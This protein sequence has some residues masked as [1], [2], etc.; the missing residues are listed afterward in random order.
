VITI[1]ITDHGRKIRTLKQ[2]IGLPRPP[3]SEKVHRNFNEDMLLR[4]ARLRPH[5]QLALVAPR[6]I[7]S[8]LRPLFQRGMADSAPSTEPD[9]AVSAGEPIS[10]SELK[11]RLKAAEKEKEK[12]AKAAA[13][14]AKAAAEPPKAK[15]ASS[16]ADEEADPTKYYDTRVA[17]IR[18]WEAA[19]INAYPHKFTV[20]MQLPDYVAK[21]RDIATNSVLDAET[22]SVAGRIFAVRTASSKLQFYDLHGEGAKIQIMAN[23]ALAADQAS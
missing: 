19:G 11:R 9:S 1:P 5:V 13:A 10:K 22:V 3:S 8:L 21:Y 18:S 4:A 6:P 7:L 2:S 14:A 20:T 15:A 23:L 12:E 17:S 16:A